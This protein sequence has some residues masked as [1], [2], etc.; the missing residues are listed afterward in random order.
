MVAKVTVA[1]AKPR[2]RGTTAN[3]IRPTATSLTVSQAGAATASTVIVAIANTSAP[4]HNSRLNGMLVF[5][6]SF[7]AAVPGFRKPRHMISTQASP[8]SQ[9]IESTHTGTFSKPMPWI[10]CRPLGNISALQVR[11]RRSS[12]RPS[13]R[14]LE[15]V[16]MLSDEFSDIFAARNTPRSVP[17]QNTHSDM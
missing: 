15:R 1:G 10:N 17:S 16:S 8:I 3:P 12:T 13:L 2:S 9:T 7:S 6:K 4:A 5:S 11:G 14:T